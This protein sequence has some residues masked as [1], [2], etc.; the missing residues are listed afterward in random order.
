[1]VKPAGRL[2]G[3][4]E[5]LKPPQGGKLVVRYHSLMTQDAPESV[6]IGVTDAAGNECM[7]VYLDSQNPWSTVLRLAT[8]RYLDNEQR[9][10]L[11]GTTL[12]RWCVALVENE[13]IVRTATVEDESHI[14]IG[15]TKVSLTRFRKFCTGQGW[16]EAYG[17]FPQD[18]FERWTYQ[19]TFQWLRNL[20]LD[21]VCIFVVRVLSLEENFLSMNELEKCVKRMRPIAPFKLTMASV[22]GMEIFHRPDRRDPLRR[23]V[24]HHGLSVP[25]SDAAPFGSRTHQWLSA[26]VPKRPRSRE[27]VCFSKAATPP[28]GVEMRDYIKSL[29]TVLDLFESLHLVLVPIQLVYERRTRTPI[30][31]KRPCTSPPRCRSRRSRRAQ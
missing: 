11:S 7:T 8:L 16:Y 12:L 15:D 18:P 5:R 24:E 20:D 13:R 25:P 30:T 19:R 23:F 22:V 26:N 27:C 2:S 4:I 3:M 29:E 28:R 1:M 9:C 14:T 10:S 6:E 17:F 21:D 31:V